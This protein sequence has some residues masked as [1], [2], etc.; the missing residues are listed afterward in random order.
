MAYK[1]TV[2]YRDGTSNLF[3][4]EGYHITKGEGWV[5]LEN[6]DEPYVMIS[7]D[8]VK[9]VLYSNSEDTN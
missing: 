1:V 2:E 8:N 9:S 5:V 3:H 7:K 6:N 4:C